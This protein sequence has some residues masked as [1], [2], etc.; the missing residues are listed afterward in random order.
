M[1]TPYSPYYDAGANSQSSFALSNSSS[2]GQSTHS[3]D[4]Q[5]TQDFRTHASMKPSTLSQTSISGIPQR[6]VGNS[7]SSLS[8]GRYTSNMSLGGHTGQPYGQAVAAGNGL[9]RN[10]VLAHGQHQLPSIHDIS[11]DWKHEQQD[12][13]MDGV[14]P[15]FRVNSTGQRDHN[16]NGGTMLPP[17]AHIASLADSQP[18]HREE[19]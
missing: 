8:L 1:R 17:F 5:L 10:Q 3:V 12:V 14:N 13:Q 15:M 4:R 6:D 16:H 18:K 19:R 9:G 11:R 2:F 7:S